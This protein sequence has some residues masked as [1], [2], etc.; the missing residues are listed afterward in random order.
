MSI[1]VLLFVISAVPYQSPDF[2]KLPEGFTPWEK[3][4]LCLFSMDNFVSESYKAEHYFWRKPIEELSLLPYTINTDNLD[5]S[6]G[7]YTRDS[8][9][10]QIKY[11][12]PDSIAEHEDPKDSD[13]NV[14]WCPHN[15]IIHVLWVPHR[16][17]TE[18]DSRPQEHFS[19]YVSYHTKGWE[20]IPI[21]DVKAMRIRGL[22]W[23]VECDG[24]EHILGSFTNYFI[25]A[26]KFD[27]YVTCWTHTFSCGETYPDRISE[28]EQA[29]EQTF[30]VKE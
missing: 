12:N 19:G 16:E 6:F 17:I 1:L 27:F 10:G 23:N 29:V 11:I 25:P 15:R 26:E 20:I 14:P 28:L 9:I 7:Y 4:N 18:P 24:T 22:W 5:S 30:R 13:I 2:P 3:Y 8:L 21:G